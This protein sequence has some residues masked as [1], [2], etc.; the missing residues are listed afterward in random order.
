MNKCLKYTLVGALVFAFN[1][2]NLYVAFVDNGAYEIF[3]WMGL[4]GAYLGYKTYRVGE[5]LDDPPS[6]MLRGLHDIDND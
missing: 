6:Y 1:P 2:A 3:L 5:E 4:L